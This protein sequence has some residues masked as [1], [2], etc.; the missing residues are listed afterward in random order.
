MKR[1]KKNCKFIAFSFILVVAFYPLAAN[2]SDV[3][4]SKVFG[5]SRAFYIETTRGSLALKL[6]EK[7]LVN[8]SSKQ[9]HELDRKG[10]YE[11][12]V[13]HR[14]SSTSD[15]TYL[16]VEVIRIFPPGKEFM[17]GIV[18]KRNDGWVRTSG[19][20]VLTQEY[21]WEDMKLKKFRWIH[22]KRDLAVAHRSLGV[23][24]HA[25]PDSNSESSWDRHKWWAEP[26][27]DNK[28]TEI[29]NELIEKINDDSLAHGSFRLYRFREM[30]KDNTENQ[31]I[32]NIVDHGCSDL[33]IRTYSPVSESYSGYYH[34]EVK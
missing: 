13:N 29:K 16:A 30:N 24:W 11:F 34:F 10:E 6:E 25:Q 12:I 9:K 32:F 33:F 18:M 31:L 21:H 4:K 22:K 2:A 15:Y 1:E 27:L 14:H 8:F 7:K 17:R 26:N 5:N 20:P 28:A 19:G 23:Q 3:P